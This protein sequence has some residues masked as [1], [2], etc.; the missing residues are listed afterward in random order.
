MADI[1]ASHKHA[2]VFYGRDGFYLRDLGSSNGTRVNQIRVD[3]PYRLTHGDRIQIGGSTIFFLQPDAQ[4][5]IPTES[6]AA[7]FACPVCGTLMTR[8]ARFCAHCG[9]TLNHPVLSKA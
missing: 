8:D 1:S 9:S 2:E 3:N 6:I 5:E 7:A 4:E